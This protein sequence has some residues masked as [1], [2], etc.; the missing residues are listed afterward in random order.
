MTQT[1]TKQ[2]ADTTSIAAALR[3]LVI[4]GSIIELRV[5]KVEG[6]KR[7]D[8]GYF[9]DIDKAAQAA[10]RYDGRASGVYFTLNPVEPA[11]LSRASN[12]VQEWAEYSTS[13]DN[14]AR[15]V[16][17][18]VDCDPRVNGKKRPAGISATD[19]EHDAAIAKAYA[20]REWLSIQGWPDA[21]VADSGNGGAL[22]Y[23]I[24]EP[25]DSTVTDLIKRC[26]EALADVF[27]DEDCDVD[28]SVFNAARIW[29]V[30]GTTA[31]KGDSTTE[32][33]H[34]RSVI[35]ECPESLEVVPTHLLRE[36]AKRVL[37]EAE[38]S[39]QSNGG[40]VVT[41]DIPGYLQK[42]G[43]G[44]A[45][46][47]TRGDRTIYV[48]DEC[49]FNSD[50]KWPDAC[51]TQENSGRVGFRCLHNSCKD[52]GWKDLR[53][54][55]E[56]G[57]YDEKPKT[58]G[59][60]TKAKPK[61]EQ[62]AERPAADAK[63]DDVYL[64]QSERIMA[65]ITD[66]GYTF[67]LNRAG[68]ILE[69][70]GRPM[71]DELAAVIRTQYRDAGLKNIAA[72][73][74][75]YRAAASRNAY[76]PVQS[77]LNDLQWDGESHITRLVQAFSSSDPLIAY[78]DGQTRTTPA[79]YLFRWLVGAV[80][81]ALDSRQHVMLVLGGRQ[82]IGKSTFTNWLCSGLPDYFLEA[83]INPG[84][85][86]ND[87]R[88]ITK[89]IWEVSELDAT[90]RKADVAALKA[91]I[92][93]NV[94][95]VRKAY[96]RLDTHAP[97]LASFIGTVNPSTGFLSDTS[98]RRFWITTLTKIDLSYQS[99]D[100]NQVWAE[101]VHRYRQGTAYE[102]LPCEVIHRDE[103][104]KQH[105]VESILEGWIDK[106]FWLTGEA[107]DRMTAADVVDHLRSKDIRL[108]GSERALA[109][110]LSRILEHLGVVKERT[111]TWRGYIGIAP[112]DNV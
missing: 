112:R 96:G 1:A 53:A 81:K 93:K 106:H 36:L 15:R 83:P 100:V 32:R 3:S 91:F 51:V 22:L 39:Y 80:A 12:R 24:D 49:P 19:T 85:K 40:R 16:L 94:V 10:A 63:A 26:L 30:Y 101:A 35:L 11:L 74:D 98:N 89:W 70:N 42:H 37:P 65:Q 104:N 107:T 79:V 2:R 13:D 38:K 56:P 69:C 31:G 109:M 21:V 14:I 8:S 95:T 29:K 45:S 43:I 68:N 108:T 97:A 61:A 55:L 92:T 25:N 78:P 75:A 111:P 4:P 20:I 87:V 59:A 58:D 88:L 99:L 9:S 41:D 102:L 77:Y 5:P 62:S 27:D 28:T 110:E 57:I 84:D 105:Q 86:D 76:H 23:R 47:K 46:S 66:W 71:D 60:A 82:G 52:K 6:R 17:F 103:V 67:R 54:K 33:P 72:L 7:T 44:V 73:E 48:L 90:T 50:H 64:P 18:P 34:R